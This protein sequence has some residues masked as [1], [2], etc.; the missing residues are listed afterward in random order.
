MLSHI[1][2]ESVSTHL[3]TG[4]L[5]PLQSKPGGFEYQ[6]RIKKKNKK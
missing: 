3:N 4:D 2:L 6:A 5:N 1:N